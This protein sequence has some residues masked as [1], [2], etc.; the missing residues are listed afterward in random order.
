[1]LCRYC[2][3]VEKCRWTTLLQFSDYHWPVLLE[4]LEWWSG[5]LSTP[6]S[7]GRRDLPFRLRYG[8]TYRSEI[9]PVLLFQCRC[10]VYNVV[11][12]F[13]SHRIDLRCNQWFASC[14][15]QRIFFFLIFLP[16]IFSSFSAFLP[17]G[18]ARMGTGTWG[19]SSPHKVRGGSDSDGN[20]HGLWRTRDVFHCR[21]V[22]NVERI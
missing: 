2:R 12:A 9:M 15:L 21:D 3:L 1:M 4:S 13:M 8:K 5:L 19:Y 20:Q 17:R 22:K 10:G 11:L 7:L 6:V 16:S 14:H 18:W